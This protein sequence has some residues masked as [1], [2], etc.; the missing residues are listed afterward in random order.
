MREKANRE[1]QRIATRSEQQHLQTAHEKLMRTFDLKLQLDKLEKRFLE[2]MPPPSLNIFDKLE[3]HAKGLKP[4]N[5]HL[6][7]LREQWK[8]VLRRAKL[9]LTALMRQAKV[10]ELEEAVKEHQD[11]VEQISL[12]LREPFET[13]SNVSR[14]RHNQMAK[15][16][17]D[18]LD[19]RA[20]AMNVD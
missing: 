5:S 12:P 13:L 17:L 2:N 10:V 14:S 11:L 19:K 4:D 6:S 20:C 1:I 15:K 8:N 9:D 7:S 18:F 3:L 16:K